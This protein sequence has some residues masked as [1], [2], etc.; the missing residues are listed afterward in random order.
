MS[1]SKNQT[2][3]II[4]GGSARPDNALSFIKDGEADGLLPGRDSLDAKKFLKI[5]DL[6]QQK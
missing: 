1:G 6:A 2:T 3:R 5:I 4:Y